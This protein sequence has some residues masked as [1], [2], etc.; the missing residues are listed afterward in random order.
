MS[1]TGILFL[2]LFFLFYRISAA[3]GRFSYCLSADLSTSLLFEHCLVRCIVHWMSQEGRTALVESWEHSMM[4][5]SAGEA[6]R[7]N[8]M[9]GAKQGQIAFQLVYKEPPHRCTFPRLNIFHITGLILSE[10]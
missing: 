6:V 8:L 3:L 9:E 5:C 2:F 1:G 7:W 10:A 4:R